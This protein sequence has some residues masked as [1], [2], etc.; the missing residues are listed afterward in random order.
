MEVSLHLEELE[1]HLRLSLI[2]HPNLEF[3]EDEFQ[4]KVLDIGK[5]FVRYKIDLY[6]V[7]NSNRM[8]RNIE[9]EILKEIIKFERNILR[10]S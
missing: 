4:V 2:T 5:D 7:T 1:E 6:A 8:H 10:S 3:K 9:N